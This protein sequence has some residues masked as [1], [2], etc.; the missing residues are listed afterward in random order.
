MMLSTTWMGIDLSRRAAG[1][2]AATCGGFPAT[3]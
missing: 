1:I 2:V 3:A